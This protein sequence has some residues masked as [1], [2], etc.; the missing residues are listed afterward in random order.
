MAT[1][2]NAGLQSFVDRLLRH[3]RLSEVEQAAILTLPFRKLTLRANQDFGR[4]GERAKH[5]CFVE[6]GLIARFGH[7]CD[8]ERQITALHIHGDMP[9]LH[10]AIRPAGI[11][12]LTTLVPATIL[13][14]AHAEVLRLAFNYPAIAE[15]FWRDCLLDAA[16]LMDWI[17]NVGR[18]NARARLAHLFCEMSAR[19]AG[20]Q[21]HLDNFRFPVTQQ[22]LGDITALTSVHVNRSLRTLR[23]EELVTFQ[24]GR[25]IVSS[26]AELVRAGEFDAAY[27]TG[28]GV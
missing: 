4:I 14:V 12:G 2:I 11:G 28:D 7:N 16:V 13:Q 19:Y 20:G 3:S 23:E 8:G 18:R 26:W 17:M 5:C 22:Q 27:L 25:V 24:N 9:D 1:S 21:G 6:D 15:A 10:S